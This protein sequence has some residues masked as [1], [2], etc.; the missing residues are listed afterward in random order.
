MKYIMGVDG[1]GTHSR[2]LVT[3]LNGNEIYQGIGKSTNIESNSLETVQKNFKDLFQEFHNKS[4]YSKEE[5]I[6]ICVGTAGADTPEAVDLITGLISNL[7]YTCFIEVL[8]DSEIALAAE[9]KGKPG[10][11]IISGTGSIGFGVNEFGEKWRVGGFGYLVGDEGSGYWVARKG[12]GAA[13]Q[14]FD[15]SGDKTILTEMLKEHLKLERFD[16]ILDFIY[17]AN[18]SEIA[19]LATLVIQ[20]CEQGDIVSKEIMDSAAAYLARMVI[21]LA[22]ELQMTTQSC[23]VIYGGGFL[24]NSM[25][26]CSSISDRILTKYPLLKP[27]LLKNEAQWGAIYIAANKAGIKI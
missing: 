8:N 3:D 2:V 24:T 5:C 4:D 9:T 18:K 25:C 19:K 17:S 20:G 11:I 26:L 16:K 12:I 21:T 10:I 23:P 15:H 13:L 6:S 1:G 27:F 7:G 14:D 22:R